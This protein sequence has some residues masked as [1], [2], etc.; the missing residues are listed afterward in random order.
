MLQFQ[1]A[2]QVWH[3][4]GTDTSAPSD[5]RQ[6]ASQ[7]ELFS[8]ARRVVELGATLN[9]VRTIESAWRSLIDESDRAYE[10]L[11]RDSTAAL[12]A[13]FPRTHGGVGRGVPDR[14]ARVESMRGAN[15]RS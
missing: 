14:E 13:L 5:S 7:R 15:L 2:R 11:Q 8:A 9:L 1:A 4:A 12:A 6:V 3:R 10:S